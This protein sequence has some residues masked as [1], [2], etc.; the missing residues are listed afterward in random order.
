MFKTFGAF[1]RSNNNLDIFGEDLREPKGNIGLFAG[2]GINELI[3]AL[4]NNNNL[5]IDVLRTINDQL[6]LHLLTA[7]IEPVGEELANVFLEQVDVLLQLQRL[8][9]LDDYSIEGV[10][11]VSVVGTVAGEVQD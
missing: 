4:N 7:N 10:E 8:S 3:D 6:L 5:M 1:G 9:Q 2:L 11:V